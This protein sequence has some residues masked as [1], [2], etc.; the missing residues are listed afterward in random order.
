ML[1]VY[2]GWSH[3]ANLPRSSVSF[4]HRLPRLSLTYYFEML[5]VAALPDYIL[6]GHLTYKCPLGWLAHRSSSM[7][8]CKFQ[9]PFLALCPYGPK[10]PPTAPMPT[11]QH[12]RMGLGIFPLFYNSNGML[13]GYDLGLVRFLDLNPVFPP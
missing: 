8:G 4:L 7:E 5:G 2:S 10:L 1:Q 9:R 3:L 6:D 12:R 13:R 11:P